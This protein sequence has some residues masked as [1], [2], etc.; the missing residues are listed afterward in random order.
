ME[1]GGAIFPITFND[2]GG[3]FPPRNFS[4]QKF[5]HTKFFPPL[6]WVKCGWCIYPTKSPSSGGPTQRRPLG[7]FQDYYVAQCPSLLWS[8]GR[9]LGLMALYLPT[10]L[11]GYHTGCPHGR[12]FADSEQ[13]GNAEWGAA[14]SK[15]QPHWEG[16]HPLLHGCNPLGPWGAPGLGFG[17]AWQR[18]TGGST[19]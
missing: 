8:L 11:F 16:G 18:H 12:A 14:G 15:S 10:Y 6:Y 17:L 3:I 4:G 13:W 5:S 19:P 1:K 7:G 9:W 2:C